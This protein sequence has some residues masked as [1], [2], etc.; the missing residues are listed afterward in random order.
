VPVV[1]Q[2]PAI[3]PAV[4]VPAPV[5]T[6]RLPVPVVCGPVV[7]ADTVIVAVLPEAVAAR[8]RPAN[9]SVCVPDVMLVSRATLSWPPE[10]VSAPTVSE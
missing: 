5:T 4:V 9:V 10:S 7:V 6:I 8:E 2:G 1:N 3:W